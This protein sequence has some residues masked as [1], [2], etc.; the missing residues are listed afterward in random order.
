[1]R[2][3]GLSS[4]R[5]LWTLLVPVLCASLLLVSVP[6]AAAVVPATPQAT[7]SFND[8]VRAVVYA[9]DTI[10]VG[11]QFTAATDS[12]GTHRRNHVAAVDAS[13]GRL[14]AWAPDADGAVWSMAVAGGHV[15]LGGNFTRVGDRPR[16]RLAK[17]AAGSG[18]V[19][20]DFVHQANRTVRAMTVADGSLYVGGQFGT[21]DGRPRD[22]LAAFTLPSG[23][24]RTDW[25]P[26]ANGTVFG[27][28]SG[29]ADRVYAG[30]TFSR[31][32]GRPGSGFAAALAPGTG[33]VVTAF[34]PAIGYAVR[35][36]EIAGDRVYAAADGPGGHLRAFRGDGGDVFDLAADGGVQAV[37][38]L[39]GA[40]YFGGHFDNVCRAARAGSS[41]SCRAGLVNRRKIGA[42]SP[43]GDLLAWAPQANSSLGVLTIDG[44]LAPER[45]AVGGAFTRF[46]GRQI[47]QPHF[48]QFG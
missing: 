17:V 6:R 23:R 21:V 2:A 44:A 27:L 45:I 19:A 32:D 3:R 11:G 29:P 28:D 42:V 43:A 46:S 36:L 10:Y 7:A 34:D 25:T 38:E 15:Y 37:T 8:S 14:R 16:R 5:R 39:G 35:D 20:G 24:L 9:G 13:T 12:T 41:G 22:R 1:V 47:V 18:T 4:R 40:I 30:G 33:A 48:A 26:S 31:I